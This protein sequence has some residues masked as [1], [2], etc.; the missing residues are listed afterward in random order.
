MNGVEIFVAHLELASTGGDEVSGVER[1]SEVGDEKRSK[2]DVKREKGLDPM[3][4]VE[5]RVAGGPANGCVV[6]PEDV[7]CASQP[8]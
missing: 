7:W 2:G 1:L 8:F 6:S 4:H 5:G 3:C